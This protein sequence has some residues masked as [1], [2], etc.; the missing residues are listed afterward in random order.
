MAPRRKVFDAVIRHRVDLQRYSRTE[1]SA[2][3]RLMGNEDA[4][5][6]DLLRKMLPRTLE[7]PTA[8]SVSSLLSRVTVTRGESFVRAKEKLF[9]DFVRLAEGE[10]VTIGKMMAK[11]VGVPVPFN[12]VSKLVAR[13]SVERPF[14]KPKILMGTWFKD[15]AKADRGRLTSAITGGIARQET[16]ETIIRQLAGT[17]R[18]GYADGTLGAARRDIE[19][20]V[21]TGTNHVAN[22]AMESW[23]KANSDFVLGSVW[24]A[25][26]DERTCDVCEGLDGEMTDEVPPAHRGCRCTKVPEFDLDALAAAGEP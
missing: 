11:A 9:G 24:T 23:V 4:R 6:I 12:P 14:G 18:A 17:A 25:L 2:M 3:I 20:A 26:L 1:A 21:R 8:A 5:V 7:R 22:A 16:N 10:G 13:Q 19:M 15:M